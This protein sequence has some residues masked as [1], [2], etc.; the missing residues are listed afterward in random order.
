MKIMHLTS[1]RFFG[2]PERQML[3]LAESLPPEFETTFVSFSEHGRC[4]D[5][6]RRVEARG[7]PAIEL[8][9]DFPNLLGARREF[10]SLIQQDEPDAILA[11]G[12]K[13]NLVGW[14]AARSASV[15]IASVSRGWTAENWK[16][17]CYEG[18]D[19]FTLPL[20]DR[21]VCVSDVQA[22]MVKRLGVSGSRITTIRNSVVA[23]RFESPRP[24]KL[25]ELQRLFPEPRSHIVAGVGRLSPEKGF[26]VFIRAAEQVVARLPEAG[27][28][29]FGEGPMR[30]RLQEE[31]RSRSLE[32][33]VVL[34]GFR[35][36]MDDLFPQFDVFVSSS[37]TEGL[38]NVV[39][40]SSAAGVPVVATEAGG[41]PEVLDDGRSGFLVPIGDAD[42]LAERTLELL[43]DRGLRERMGAAGRDRARQGFS[44]NTQQAEYQDLFVSLASSREQQ[45]A[46]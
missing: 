27:F 36:D 7:F 17:W 13:A 42:A 6:L 35:D 45:S 30:F 34:P 24:E 11:H 10:A 26:R 21:T 20:M 8:Q 9:R 31:I 37:Y 18:L 22:E 44:F 28:V 43:Q 5:F 15:P 40:E 14:S 32:S 19:R 2:G 38:P 4:R 41:T 46:A 23:D 33:H 39:L 16:V 25:A 12:Y 3:G 29:I 1:S